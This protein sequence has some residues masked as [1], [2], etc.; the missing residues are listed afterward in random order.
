MA[1]K[2]EGIIISKNVTSLQIKMH[3]VREP[4]L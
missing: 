4:I 3:E 2:L 1:L